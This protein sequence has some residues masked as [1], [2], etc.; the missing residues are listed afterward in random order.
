MTQA[1][2]LRVH[3]VHQI[4]HSCKE[5]PELGELRVS[6]GVM[7][8]ILT[9][10]EA[11][12]ESAMPVTTPAKRA[13]EVGTLTTETIVSLVL[14]IICTSIDLRL[15]ATAQLLVAQSVPMSQTD[16]CAIDVLM[17]ALPVQVQDSV[18][19]VIQHQPNLCS[20]TD[21]AW[22]RAYLDSLQAF[23]AKVQT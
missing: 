17:D 18:F 6:L 22:I 12:N 2:A 23:K 3:V 4:L 21:S 14:T 20:T 15:N 8:G 9:T 13:E 10:G 11:L 16:L 7:K 19:G 5:M 1:F